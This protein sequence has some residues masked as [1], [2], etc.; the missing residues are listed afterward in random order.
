MLTFKYVY[1]STKPDSTQGFLK[2][3]DGYCINLES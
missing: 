2:E 3:V 1:D